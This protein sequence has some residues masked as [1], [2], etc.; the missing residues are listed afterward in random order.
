MCLKLISFTI[1]GSLSG[2]QILIVIPKWK[3]YFAL[4]KTKSMRP[5]SLREKLHALIDVLPAP[6]I[7]EIYYVLFNNYR[8][9][10]KLA[11][12]PLNTDEEITGDELDLMVQQ[13]L[14]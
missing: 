1:S 4:R 9:E 7:T 2:A 14:C 10:F 12:A 13:L 6:K 8:E 5:A 3:V 11:F